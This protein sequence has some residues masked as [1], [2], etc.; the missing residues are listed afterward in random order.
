MKANS[1]AVLDDISDKD[2]R[3]IEKIMDEQVLDRPGTPK[4][5]MRL[6]L[7]PFRDEGALYSAALNGTLSFHGVTRN[8]P[9]PRVSQCLMK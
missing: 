3:E 1:L 7:L 8:Q 2:R 6:R 9:C 5:C 4:S